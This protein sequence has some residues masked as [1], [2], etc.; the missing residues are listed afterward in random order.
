VQSRVLG[1][2]SKGAMAFVSGSGSLVT[3]RN[4]RPRVTPRMSAAS[5]R[6]F[7]IAIAGGC[8]T[9]AAL[10]ALAKDKID[11]DLKDLDKEVRKLKYEEEVLQNPDQA[12]GSKSRYAT[13]LNDK[14][15]SY[16]A[17]QESQKQDNK[18]KYSAVI[19]KEKDELAKLKSAFSKQ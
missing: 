19:A 13:K 6:E 10:P 18:Q 5:R 14:V 3:Y 4:V 1:I 7:L 15:G 11:L 16:R 8:L 17:V 12:E 2:G 9:G